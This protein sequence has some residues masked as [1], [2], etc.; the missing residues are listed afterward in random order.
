MPHAP[1]DVRNRGY[2]EAKEAPA[3]TGQFLW[4]G[5]RDDHVITVDVHGTRVH[6]YGLMHQRMEGA[7]SAQDAA[8]YLRQVK[9]QQVFLE[10]CKYRYVEIINAILQN[11]ELPVPHRLRVFRAIHGGTM[12]REFHAS[13]IAAKEIGAS[14]FLVDR[15]QQAVKNRCLFTMWDNESGRSFMNYMPLSLVN[16]RVITY[17]ELHDLVSTLTPRIIH[18]LFQE[19]NLYM[20]HQILTQ[21]DKEARDV[22]VVCGL[23]QLRGLAWLLKHNHTLDSRGL[24]ILAASPPPQ[25]PAF[26]FFRF[27]LPYLGVG[28]LLVGVSWVLTNRLV[29]PNA[30]RLTDIRRARNA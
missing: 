20:A 4:T 7:A 6:L 22:V 28:V 23:M 8:E 27:F 11:K 12:V 18:A 16:R 21:I 5:T 30:G 29:G 26:L 3:T 2:L 24:A 19:R 14:L 13:V 15:T 25:G 10:L 9:P 17:Q 1:A